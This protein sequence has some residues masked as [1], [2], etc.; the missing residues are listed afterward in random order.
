MCALFFQLFL[1]RSGL[2]ELSSGLSKS[3]STKVF[4]AVI[5]VINSIGGLSKLPNGLSQTLT[6][7]TVCVD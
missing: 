1:N 5:Y 7:K 4:V 6:K 3:A 2:S